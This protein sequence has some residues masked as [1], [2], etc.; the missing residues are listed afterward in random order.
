MAL[1]ID[2]KMYR[3]IGKNAAHYAKGQQPS[4]IPTV[5]DES[6]TYKRARAE[7]LVV[8]LQHIE[9]ECVVRDKQGT[10]LEILFS[11]LEDEAQ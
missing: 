3:A 5:W 10:E 9:K 2:Q 11:H 7:P 8:I 4:T 1:L 6:I